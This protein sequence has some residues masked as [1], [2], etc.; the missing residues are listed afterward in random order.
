MHCYLFTTSILYYLLIFGHNH[1]IPFLS[2]SCLLLTG[3]CPKQSHAGP[4]LV[5]DEICLE[6]NSLIP[7]YLDY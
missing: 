6:A 2:T 1:G 5:R 3:G 7:V 4:D